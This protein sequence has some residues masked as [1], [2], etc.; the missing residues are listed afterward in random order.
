M[1]AKKITVP[2]WVAWQNLIPGTR[3][4]KTLHITGWVYSDLFQQP[5]LKP[6]KAP[7]LFELAF[8]RLKRPPHFPVD[9]QVPKQVDPY[10][11]PMADIQTI[12]TIRLPGQKRP[13]QVPIEI[14][15]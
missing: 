8:R 6:L 15:T 2:Y 14:V 11:Q 3:S 5:Y 7:L 1:K 10:Q 9:L 4:R 12:V 13:I